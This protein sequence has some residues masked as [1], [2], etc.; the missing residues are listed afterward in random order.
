MTEVLISLGA[1]VFAAALW[2]IISEYYFGEVAD[3]KDE[4][5]GEEGDE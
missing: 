4:E 2:G 1:I 5:L 3:K